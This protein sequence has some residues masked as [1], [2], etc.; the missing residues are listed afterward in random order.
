[1]SDTVIKIENLSKEYRL[2]TINHGTLY[3]DLQSWS[4][5][6]RG[7]E[8][9]NSKIASAGFK[10]QIGSFMA[11]DDISFE[12][13]QG[14]VLGIVGRNGAGKSTLLKIIS[15]VTMPTRG[16]VKIKGRVASLLEV[17]T[18]FHP[19]LTGRENIYLNGA[20]LGMTKKEI[21]RKFDE[22][23]DFAEI[24]N[25]ID[26]PVKRYSSGMYVRLAF[27]VAANLEPEILII[28]EVLA[29]GDA[30]F[31]KKCL[32]K[33]EQVSTK[34]GRTVLFVSHNMAM[35]T[36][37]CTSA[38]LLD[39]GKLRVRGNTSDVV[40]SY[41]TQYSGSPASF[42]FRSSNKFIGDDH[43]MLISGS[44]VDS[45]GNVA[46]EFD[47]R[48]PVTITMRYRVTRPDHYRFIPNFHFYAPDGTCAFI[49]GPQEVTTESGEFEAVCTIP[50]NYL[51]D[52]TYFVGLALSSMETGVKA[53][54]YEQNALSFNVK[55]PIDNVPT[56]NGYAG[57]IPGM[58]RPKL[59]WK[60]RGVA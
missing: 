14:D 30:Q 18:G 39:S 10:V 53:H 32:G 15:R 49:S 26:T 34:Q 46:N 33:M 59:D 6:I 38:V 19:E 16:E 51:N 21:G 7:K 55:D 11:L 29:V 48:N 52:G 22:I 41:Y 24:E 57:P 36:S 12:V 54:F 3:R 40:L 8:D 35:I 17:G 9:P 45:E 4:A 44:V 23:V 5:R 60:I 50:G 28:D 58:I 37:L 43:A 25:F 1:M 20:I 27:A 56:R 13:K 47:I 42:D 2:G 31:Q